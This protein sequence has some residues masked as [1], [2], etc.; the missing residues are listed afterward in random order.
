MIKC[1]WGRVEPLEASFASL[2]LELHN[3]MEE[4]DLDDTIDYEPPLALNPEQFGDSLNNEDDS[5][6]M[7]VDKCDGN[8]VSGNDETYATDEESLPEISD[9]DSI[10]DRDFDDDQDSEVYRF[11]WL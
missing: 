10:D 5:E 11:V 8:S 2:N 1:Q 9:I 7:F 3:P 6:E 4:T